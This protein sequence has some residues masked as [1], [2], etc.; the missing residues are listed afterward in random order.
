MNDAAKLAAAAVIGSVA[1]LATTY[2]A[3]KVSEK[4]HA[5]Q[6]AARAAEYTKTQKSA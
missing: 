5:K 2:V 4:I 6:V 3:R 1:S